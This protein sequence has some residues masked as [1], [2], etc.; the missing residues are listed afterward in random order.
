MLG[1]AD[2][3][4]WTTAATPKSRKIAARPSPAVTAM[5]ARAGRVGAV[6]RG[7]A[8]RG[9]R[10]PGRVAAG[11]A[12]SR[13]D[14]DAGAAG[15]RRGPRLA[16]VAGLVV[17]VLDADPAQRPEA[18]A[19]ADDEVRPLVV[20]VDLERPAVAGDEHGFADRLEVVADRVDVERRRA[21]RPGAGTSS[22]SRTPRRR[23]RPASTAWLRPAARR[24]PV[25]TGALPE[26][27]EQRALEQPVQALPARV[28]DAGLAQDREQARRPRD[29]PLG[30]RPAS[31]RGR[32]RCRCRARPPRPRPPPIRG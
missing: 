28:D 22:R 30:R 5:T 12:P 6:R 19:V 16:D 24:R 31:R 25:V 10:C 32:P 7:D 3:P 29:R 18:Q 11:A 1:L 27:V 14:R 15:E 8:R 2:W 21:R 26:Q 4:P 17:E 20:D 23:A 9:R 13:P